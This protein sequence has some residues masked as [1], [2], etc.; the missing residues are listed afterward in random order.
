MGNI[1]GYLNSV[2][3]PIIQEHTFQDRK[4]I[5]HN[6]DVVETT[7]QLALDFPLE[8]LECE[9]GAREIHAFIANE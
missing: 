3:G 8:N 6:F 9:E 2:S 5:A 4:V 7:Q 1:T